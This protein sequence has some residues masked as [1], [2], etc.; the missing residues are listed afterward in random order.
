[1][2]KIQKLIAP[3]NIFLDVEVND[4]IGAL[5]AVAER[6]GNLTSLNPDLLLE[7][8]EEREK[9][10]STS[11]G[12]GFAIP[13]AK[14]RGLEEI[15]VILLRFRKPVVFDTNE[16]VRMVAA[17]VSPPDEPAAHLQVLSQI[18]RMIKRKDFRQRLLEVGT[19]AEAI[20]ILKET[21]AR[22]GL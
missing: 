10:G 21:A 11:V 7:A 9:L 3:E 17:V 13:H 12:E 22:E 1:M 20:E 16:K 14:L 6:L 15:T 8:L 18:A 19:E 2:K 5:R 4:R